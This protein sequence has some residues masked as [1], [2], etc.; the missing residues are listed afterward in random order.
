[1]RNNRKGETALHDA[2]LFASV[3]HLDGANY[4]HARLWDAWRPLLTNQFHDILPGSSI[5]EV[6]DQCDR[7][8]ADALRAAD[9]VA[10]RAV[11]TL[12]GRIDT[13]GDGEPIVVFNTLSWVRDGA[14]AIDMP[15][16][17]SAI[18]VIAPNGDVVP[19]QWTGKSTLLFEVD[20]AP[21][22]GWAVYRVVPRKRAAQTVRE[23]KAT[24]TGME[25][26]YLQIEFD[27]H[28]R[29]VRLFDKREGRE[30]LAE[31]RRANV[32]QLFDDRPHLH[33]AWDFDHNYE[34]TAW[35]PGAAE[36]IEVI[37]RGP[38]RAVVR[39]VR[40][41]ER[42]TILQDIT[43][44]AR[45]PRIDFVT[46]VDWRERHVLMKAAFPVDV[47]ASNAT[48]EIQYGT[49][50]RPTHHNTAHD[51]ARYENTALRWVDLSEGNYGVT[52]LNDC[53]YGH[54]VRENVLRI[55]L[56]RSST[57]PDPEADQGAH[58]F[59][60]SLYPHAGDWRN[61][62][63]RQ[64]LELNTPIAAHR[65]TPSRGGL[66][67]VHS[68]ASVDAENVVIDWIK[69][70]EDSNAIIVRLYEAHGQRGPVTVTFGQR[71]RQVFECDLMEENEQRVRLNG[72]SVELYMTPYE[73]RT[74]K[75]KFE[76]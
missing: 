16:K 61:G 72:S 38:V 19:H 41:T 32:L 1:K 10:S 51:R 50:D 75:V 70:H 22:L 63:V 47:R 48:Y 4:D 33:D 62:A 28:G 43:L 8:Y 20:A 42:S 5:R 13:R 53:K 21:P 66:P 46:T 24:A 23:L 2:E 74:L 67:P 7:D 18:S 40:K 6:Y 9:D 25:N 35:E 39:V 29:I 54:D 36:S 30:V 65:T 27:L 69:K 11:A 44:H 59:T 73:L 68:F 12:A 76:K 3:A 34:R 17:R 45:S 57:D 55:S 14:V 52:L 60:Y 64:G 71:P 31:G 49:I 15:K 26:E 37:E 56:L 58:A